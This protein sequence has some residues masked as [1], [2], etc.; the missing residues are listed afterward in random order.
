M[1]TPTPSQLAGNG[2]RDVEDD[3]DAED[4]PPKKKAKKEKKEGKKEKDEKKKEKVTIKFKTKTDV[5]KGSSKLG[6][7][8]VS[9]TRSE[10]EGSTKRER[11]DGGGD[12]TP[13]KKLKLSKEGSGAGDSVSSVS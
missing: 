3:D 8:L 6:T 12:E 9:D 13:K 1:G 11:D 7:S 5:V 4:G 2:K 10:R